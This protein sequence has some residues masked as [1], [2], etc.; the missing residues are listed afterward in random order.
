MNRLF[1]FPSDHP[2]AT[3]N[4]TRKTLPL[5]D[6]ILEIWVSQYGPPS[7]A[8]PRA[9]V[10]E[11]VGNGSRAEY[12][13]SF[14]SYA[15]VEVLT[16]VWVVNYPG[17][18]GSTGPAKL[19]SI[20]LAAEAAYRE[21]SEVADGRPILLAGT[22][23]GTTAA[24]YLAARHEA[25]A[26]MLQ[27]PP[28]L[29]RLVMGRFG[30][31]NLWLLAAPTALWLPDELNSV[32]N[33]AKVRAPLLL[34]MAEQDQVVPIRFQRLIANAYA[35]PRQVIEMP[36]IGHNDGLTPDAVSA[37]ASFLSGHLR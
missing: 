16:E 28:P 8:G 10:L 18:G 36:K 26:V 32:K 34:L 20:P 12:G 13:S 35:G 1:L 30:W 23:M 6:G 14:L 5:G 9:S 2:I 33:A 3:P 17:Y 21:L 37:L 19:R 25:R 31:W 24:L 4:Q 22:S 29:Q 27:N 11:F 7:A 15:S